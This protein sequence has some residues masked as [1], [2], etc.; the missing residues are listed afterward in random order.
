MATDTRS[1]VD[2]IVWLPLSN[3][4]AKNPSHSNCTVAAGQSGEAGHPPRATAPATARGKEGR[5]RGG[6]C[7]SY[8]HVLHVKLAGE[9][10][11]HPLHGV[12]LRLDAQRREVPV[13]RRVRLPHAVVLDAGAE[14][15]ERRQVG[16]DVCDG[17]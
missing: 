10:E 15:E 13:Q 12:D 17:P 4:A 6:A 5:G 2:A 16:R 7:L 1:S 9:H 14:G 11:A 8:Q 3:L